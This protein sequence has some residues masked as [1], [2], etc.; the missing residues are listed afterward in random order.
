[1]ECR[2]GDVAPLLDLLLAVDED[3]NRPAKIV[4][5]TPKP[6]HLGMS[7][8]NIRLYDEEVEVAAGTRISARLRAEEDHAH[9]RACLLG[10]DACC[11]LDL[12]VHGLNASDWS[13]YLDMGAGMAAQSGQDPTERG[14][15]NVRR[16]QS[17]SIQSFIAAPATAWPI[18][19]DGD[20]LGR[21]GRRSGKPPQGCDVLLGQYLDRVATRRPAAPQAVMRVPGR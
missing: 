15:L 17:S 18:V 7:I 12:C 11:L 13:F 4:Q 8:G 20:A 16:E 10:Q 21:R 3:V 2:T 6:D 14:Y 9:G 19:R 1:M 5:G